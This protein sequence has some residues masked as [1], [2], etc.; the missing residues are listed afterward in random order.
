MWLLAEAHG[1]HEGADGRRRFFSPLQLSGK[2]VMQAAV[3]AGEPGVGH[4][5]GHGAGADAQPELS[6]VPVFF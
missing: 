4:G 2:P 1:N 5:P 6:L 3:P